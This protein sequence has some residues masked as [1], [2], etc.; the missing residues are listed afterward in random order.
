MYI[1]DT[2]AAV[3]TPPGE[4]GIGI[5]RVSG[6]DAERI[7]AAIFIKKERNGGFQSHRF[8]YGTLSDPGSGRVVD[9]AMAVLMKKPR[10]YTREDV[11]ELHCHGGYESIRETLALVL[12]QGAR[13]AEPGE[14]TRRAFLNG[15]ID[16]VQAEAVMDIVAAKTQE[17]LHRAQSQREGALSSRLNFVRDRLRHALAFLEA[18]IDFPEED[19][20]TGG[21]AMIDG[22]IDECSDELG[23]LLSGYDEGR[24]FREGVSV[25]IAGKPNVGKSSL[26]NRLLR[27][28]R[29]IV[30]HLPGTTRDVIEDWLNIKGLPIKLIDTAGIRE[31]EDTVE[32]I[33]VER[34]LQRVDEADL[35]LFVVDRSRPLDDDDRAVF[36][37]V[38]GKK[39][40][41]IENK[42]DL[43]HQLVL[44]A[45]MLAL[46]R[47][48]VTA[49]EGRGIDELCDAIFSLF[50]VS[51]LS[52]SDR[53][54]A[55]TRARHRDA[56]EQA[57]SLLRLFQ[58]NLAAELD[59]ELLAVDLRDA[60]AA[61][62][63]VTGETTPDDILDLIFSSFCIGK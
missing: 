14:F 45:E 55:L 36:Q 63:T 34:A 2:I 15:R 28:E 59:P 31:T 47:I 17:S 52:R 23:R 54:A 38:S 3:A 6:P 32:R 50:A 1:E 12:S 62:G 18:H 7:A 30:T 8:Y 53:E 4:G 33:G 60:L 13:S 16:L 35:V 24:I 51:G 56:V 22:W 19:I 29:A 44:D 20:D 25:M 11:L 46:P 26:L 48:A 10:S 27:E 37:R 21:T 58:A 42:T 5:I 39:T 57:L 43:P 41:V 40:I 61:I 49:A 9:E